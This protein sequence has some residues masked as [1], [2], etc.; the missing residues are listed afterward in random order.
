MRTSM[1]LCPNPRQHL[2]PGPR[3]H[4][5]LPVLEGSGPVTS[6][7]H[8]VNAILA[9]GVDATMNQ[10]LV[11]GLVQHLTS[12]YLGPLMVV[13]ETSGGDRITVKYKKN[14]PMATSGRS[15]YLAWT[16]ILTPGA[17]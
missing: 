11:A 3:C 16:A 4:L 9:K 7:P 12:P 6:R 15:S 2:V 13:Q 17:N 10:Y 8:R 5:R 14:Y 1:Q